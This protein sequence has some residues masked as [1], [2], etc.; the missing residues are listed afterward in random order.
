VNVP[1]WQKM[2]ADSSKDRATFSFLGPSDGAVA[3]RPAAVGS[4]GGGAVNTVAAHNADVLRAVLST[5]AAA[6][7]SQ[8]SKP[9]AVRGA[10]GKPIG[11]GVRAPVA[12]A[13]PTAG[14]AALRFFS[15]AAG[16]RAAAGDEAEAARRRRLV[17]AVKLKAKFARR[18]TGTARR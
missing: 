8:S 18:V 2:L 17:G 10:A 5:S 16:P 7:L 13:A 1:S 12:A 4:D 6:V 9:T 14:A 15:A 11:G 3:A